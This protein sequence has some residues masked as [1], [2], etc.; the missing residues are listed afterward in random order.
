MNFTN[1]RIGDRFWRIEKS[2]SGSPLGVK[3]WVLE[4]IS[5]PNNIRLSFNNAGEKAFA[6]TTHYNDDWF[7]TEE[8]ANNEIMNRLNN[9]IVYHRS[10]IESAMIVKETI[11]S[12]MI[13]KTETIM[14][15]AER[16]YNE[17]GATACY[18]FAKELGLK[19]HFCNECNVPTPTYE[20]H[21]FVCGL[22]KT[23]KRL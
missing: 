16:L 19:F 5:P 23:E 1:F 20:D 15:K 14:E 21:C 9:F 6:Y 11:Y 2:V 7:R 10:A 3:E 13:Q 12:K 22:N 18:N 4:T 8:E 17:G